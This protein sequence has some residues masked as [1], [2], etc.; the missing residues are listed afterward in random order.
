MLRLGSIRAQGAFFRGLVGA[1][2]SLGL[3][4]KIPAHEKKR[5][6]DGDDEPDKIIHI[7]IFSRRGLRTAIMPGFVS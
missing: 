3:F 5:Y 4:P 1:R 6:D 2:F 7:D